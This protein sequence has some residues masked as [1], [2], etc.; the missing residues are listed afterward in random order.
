MSV[1]YILIMLLKTDPLLPEI[2]FKWTSVYFS[3]LILTTLLR[4]NR[5][6]RTHSHAVALWAPRVPGRDRVW[7]RG[8]AVGGGRPAG[9]ASLR[10]GGGAA[11]P[12]FRMCVGAG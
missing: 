9:V 12:H 5:A 10:A 11:R 3:L 2:Q 4:L 7:P 1:C 8:G 6:D